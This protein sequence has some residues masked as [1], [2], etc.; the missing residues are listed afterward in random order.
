LTSPLPEIDGILQRVASTQFRSSIDLADAYEQIRIQPDH[1]EWMA[2]TTPS[3]TM[4]SKV[5][6][7]GDCN[8]SATFQL[9]MTRIF[10]PYIG[11]FM[12]VYLDNLVIYSETME[13]HVKHIKLIID[14]LEKEKF[15]VSAK[16]LKF[17]EDE[18]YIL[19]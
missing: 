2:M 16:K 3:G 8:A 13:E 9:V 14:I 4:I 12:E 5:M 1:V 18:L 15:Y 7:E 19:G 10:A 6:Q 17:L 11:Q